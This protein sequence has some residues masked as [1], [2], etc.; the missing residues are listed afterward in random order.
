[1]GLE[2]WFGTLYG[3]LD[4]F[5]GGGLC[6]IDTGAIFIVLWIMTMDGFHG[7]LYEY[8]KHGLIDSNSS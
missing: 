4:A 6:L 7:W 3:L 8:W 2:H 1:M 5:F